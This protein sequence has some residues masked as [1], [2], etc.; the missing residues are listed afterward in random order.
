MNKDIY[1]CFNV[2]KDVTAAAAEAAAAAA[3]AVGHKSVAKA[4]HRVELDTSRPRK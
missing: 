2:N 3:E 4:K 1:L